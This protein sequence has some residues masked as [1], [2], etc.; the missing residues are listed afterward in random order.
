MKKGYAVLSAI[1]PD[2]V[3]IVRDITSVITQFGCNIEESR[4]ISLGG[5]FSVIMLI[6]GRESDIDTLLDDCECWKELDD[7]HID[8]RRTRPAPQQQEGIPYQIKTL[9]LNTP[10]VVFA[11]TN[12]LQSKGISIHELDTDTSA[13]PFT[14]SPMFRMRI[15]FVARSVGVVDELREE[16]HQIGHDSNIDIQLIPLSGN[17]LD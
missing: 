10:G 3:G 8:L 12:L 11:I 7:L 15:E 1:G 6:D 17:P 16:L 9:S 14:G 13:A 2:R 5:D 4:M